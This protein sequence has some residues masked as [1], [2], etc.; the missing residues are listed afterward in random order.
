MLNK[1][2]LEILIIRLAFRA[3][4][5]RVKALWGLGRKGDF[6]EQETSVAAHL[7]E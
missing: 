6:N 4:W 3:A 5:P 7:G 2:K 1:I